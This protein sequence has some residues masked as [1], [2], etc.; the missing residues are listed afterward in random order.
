VQDL[1][2]KEIASV[3]SKTSGAVRVAL[4]RAVKQLKNILKNF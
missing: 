2:I 1:S 3:Q 4:H